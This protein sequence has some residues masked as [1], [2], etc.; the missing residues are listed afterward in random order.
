[1]D[2]DHYHFFHCIRQASKYQP[3]SRLTFQCSRVVDPFEIP[4]PPK[5][6]DEFLI[7]ISSKIPGIFVEYCLTYALRTQIKVEVD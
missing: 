1:M 5:N 4:V 6:K 3:F 2:R 7:P